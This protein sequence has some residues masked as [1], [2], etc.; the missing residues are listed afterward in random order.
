MQ[1]TFMGRSVPSLTASRGASQMAS[2]SYVFGKDDSNSGAPLTDG[3]GGTA[4]V[5]SL[6]ACHHCML[7]IR[8]T[9]TLVQTIRS[10]G[11]LCSQ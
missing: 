9:Y 5:S 2:R 6:L 4:P 11:M 8:L 1:T 10:F 7:L 3:P